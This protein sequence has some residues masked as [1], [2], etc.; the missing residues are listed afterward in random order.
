MTRL[1]A[2]VLPLANK[3]FY[4]S[5]VVVIASSVGLAALFF[6]LAHPWWALNLLAVLMVAL[7]W[8]RQLNFAERSAE[9]RASR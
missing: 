4:L 6:L 3:L 1:G 2:V 5:M 8:T 9:R 7:Y